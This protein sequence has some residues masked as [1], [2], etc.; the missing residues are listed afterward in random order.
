MTIFIPENV[1]KRYS[2]RFSMV[3]FGAFADGAPFSAMED[4]HT[5][6]LTLEEP[7]GEKN[8]S[9]FAVYD[10]HG[11]AHLIA[12]LNIECSPADRL[13]LPQVTR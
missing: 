13:L 8:N 2:A 3:L 6:R 5:T 11:G 9:F 7:K 12:F 1:G 4:A 10:G